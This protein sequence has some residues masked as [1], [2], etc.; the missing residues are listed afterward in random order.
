MFKEFIYRLFKNCGKRNKSN[1]DHWIHKKLSKLKNGSRL[2]DAGA[3]ELQYKKFCKH[4]K[5]ISQDFCEYDGRGD[6]K[7]LQTGKWNISKIDIVSDITNIPEPDNSYDAILCSEV[8][9]HIPDPEKAIREF[10]R[11]L[12]KGGLLIL[13]T[14]VSS[15]THFAPYYFYNGFSRYYF[16]K[17]LPEYGFNIKELLYN[18]N[19]FEYLATEIQRIPYMAKR[20]S[21]INFFENVTYRIISISI[22]LFLNKLS[23]NDVGSSELVSQ[24]I[25]I[26]AEKT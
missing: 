26:F 24:G 17:Y 7:G 12:K 3:G 8:F 4:L 9:Q 14:P 21:K 2:L 6:S 18:G 23:T 16:E 5:Y 15:F 25:H 22:L 10:S 11:L 1:R 13:T 20:Y 19:Y